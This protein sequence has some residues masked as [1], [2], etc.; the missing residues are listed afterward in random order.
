MKIYNIPD[1]Y[2]KVP[3][4]DKSKLYGRFAYDASEYFKTFI[5]NAEVTDTNG[6]KQIL[7]GSIKINGTNNEALKKEFKTWCQSEGFIDYLKED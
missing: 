1:V 6:N 7:T 5:K 2:F 3:K 4:D